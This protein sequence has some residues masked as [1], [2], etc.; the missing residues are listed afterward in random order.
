M[1]SYILKFVD[2]NLWLID[3]IN[4]IETLQSLVALVP[5]DIMEQCFSWY[6]EKTAL[7]NGMVVRYRDAEI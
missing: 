4:K 5:V 7:V 2:E 6:A 1:L 3:R